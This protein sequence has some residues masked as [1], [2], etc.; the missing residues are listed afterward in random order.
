MA[1]SASD[2]RE[3]NARRVE[4]CGVETGS[5]R[6]AGGWGTVASPTLPT[7]PVR[8]ASPTS[9]HVTPS[10]NF[11]RRFC[12]GTAK[13]PGLIDDTSTCSSNYLV[14][15]VVVAVAVASWLCHGRTRSTG[16]PDNAAG[17][18]GSSDV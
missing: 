11:A 12:S 2:C 4:H 15:V 3:T 1:P 10:G 8:C 9:G 14:Q 17:R 7:V 16:R 13:R 5:L 18:A 6:H